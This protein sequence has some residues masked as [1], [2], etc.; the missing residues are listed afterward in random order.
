[1]P[2]LNALYHDFESIQKDNQ[3][4][5]IDILGDD[6]IAMGSNLTIVPQISDAKG[7][8]RNLWIASL[9]FLVDPHG[10]VRASYPQ[11]DIPYKSVCTY[12]RLASNIQEA[13]N[14]ARLAFTY[15]IPSEQG[16]LGS[17][18]IFILLIRYTPE[19]CEGFVGGTQSSFEV[20]E[21]PK[22]PWLSLTEIARTFFFTFV[23]P[24]IAVFGL[25]YSEKTGK[26]LAL[27]VENRI[28]ML[29]IAIMVF[30]FILGY[31]VP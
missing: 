19:A 8:V 18:M 28:F 23:G 4:Y 26:T 17:W 11:G 20:V 15:R 9:V 6:R 12:P 14:N 10:V 7:G 2:G 22:A 29:G 24:A 25:L 5:R 21:G 1:M 3:E 27:L 16:S 30:V 13:M 31:L